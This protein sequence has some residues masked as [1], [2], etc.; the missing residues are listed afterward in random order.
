[1]LFWFLLFTTMLSVM[2]EKQGSFAFSSENVGVKTGDRIIHELVQSGQDPIDEHLQVGVIQITEVTFIPSN[3]G[4][5]NDII[6]TSFERKYQANRLYYSEDRKLN[7]SDFGSTIIYTDWAYWKDIFRS[8]YSNDS[9][10]N[11]ILLIN[12]VESNDTVTFSAKGTDDKSNSTHEIE[13]INGFD[14]TYEKQ[15][16]VLVEYSWFSAHNITEGNNIF[17]ELNFEIKFIRILNE[18]NYAI[19]N[20]EGINVQISYQII[21]LMVIW[22]AKFKHKIFRR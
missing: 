2:G 17:Y 4:D 14:F 21:I 9:D 8:L 10:I 13:F 20:N 16:G 15:T 6:I 19:T 11:S 1:M 3:I 18:P 7:L 22:I 12:Y 5:S